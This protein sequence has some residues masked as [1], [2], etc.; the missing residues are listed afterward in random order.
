MFCP[1]TRTN[2]PSS[3]LASESSSFSQA[4]REQHCHPS[5]CL[6]PASSLSFPSVP[7]SKSQCQ[8]H[9]VHTGRWPTC[10]SQLCLNSENRTLHYVYLLSV[11]ET[12]VPSFLD[13]GFRGE[14]IPSLEGRLGP[15]EKTHS[16]HWT[17]VL[18]V[19]FSPASPLIVDEGQPLFPWL[20]PP[21][22]PALAA[23]FPSISNLRE[24]PEFAICIQI[25]FWGQLVL[26]ATA[27]RAV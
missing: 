25:V 1:P 8:W 23:F 20:S 26:V 11:N 10:T 22:L 6:S 4:R 7:G 2:D 9:C 15:L 16:G 5:L 17:G 21:L 14:A 27:R 19:N 24:V 3:G 13:N 18:R 12:E